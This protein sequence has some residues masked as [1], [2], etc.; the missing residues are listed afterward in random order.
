QHRLSNLRP[1]LNELVGRLDRPKAST[2]EVKPNQELPKEIKDQ[3]ARL[4]NRLAL[5]GDRHP[6]DNSNTQFAALGLWVA[7]R[8]GIPVERAMLR[9]AGRF[10]MSQAPDGSWHY[11]SATSPGR[12]G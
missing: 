4:N 12:V 1:Q 10:R 7:R 5:G 6:A 8:H 9:L 2:T 11:M 3:L